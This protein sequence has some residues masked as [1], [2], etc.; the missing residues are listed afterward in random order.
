MAQGLKK[1]SKNTTKGINKKQTFSK[2]QKV[3]KKTKKGSSVKLSKFKDPISNAIQK[4]AIKVSKQINKNVET[5]M[6]AKC[7]QAGDQI[8]LRDV[9]EVGKK[10]V[11]DVKRSMFKKKKSRM[12]EKLEE[13]RREAR[14]KAENAFINKKK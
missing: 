2:L 14:E 12:E 13:L 4:N 7:L 9:K 1:P 3:K 5:M 10:H 8:S 11:R 6:A